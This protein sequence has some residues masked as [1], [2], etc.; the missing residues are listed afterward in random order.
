MFLARPNCTASHSLPLSVSLFQMN[1]L[2][3]WA[4]HGMSIAH[5]G[6][7]LLGGG[8][9][10]KCVLVPQLG[11]TQN[12]HF[13]LECPGKSSHRSGC[14]ENSHLNSVQ[15]PTNVGGTQR[16]LHGRSA[17]LPTLYAL[18]SG[19]QNIS[20]VFLLFIAPFL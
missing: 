15:R 3:A 13:T 12:A 11:H 20:T 5:T 6:T 14:D 1:F 18:H 8:G 4:V 19:V 7:N 17:E 16:R 9:G 10:D 2:Y